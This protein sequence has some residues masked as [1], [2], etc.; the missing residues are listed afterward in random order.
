MAAGGFVA[1]YYVDICWLPAGTGM[2]LFAPGD[3]SNSPGFGQTGGPG[4][5]PVGQTRRYQAAE[6]IPG[7]S[8]PTLA[9]INA[10][11]KACADDIAGATGTPKIS[12]AELALI[13]GWATGGV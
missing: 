5:Q 8:A 9:N 4:T 7:G 13:Q 11:L 6:V 3:Q 10:A 2:A 1:R 12:A